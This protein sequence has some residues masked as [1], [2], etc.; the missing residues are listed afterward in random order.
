MP[1]HCQSASMRYMSAGM[2]LQLAILINGIRRLFK[3]LCPLLIRFCHYQIFL[4][5]P[6][7][8]LLMQVKHKLNSYRPQ[9]VIVQI[10]GV[11][12]QHQTNLDLPLLRFPLKI[13][14]PLVEV[15]EVILDGNMFTQP[16]TFTRFISI[17]ERK[18]IKFNYKLVM[19]LSILFHQNMEEVVDQLK[20][21]G[22]CLVDNM[23]IKFSS[24]LEI[25][26][27]P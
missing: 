10:I 22:R 15:E 19:A 25:E 14:Q 20:I 24:D 2:L 3:I 8:S 1:R 13:L 5:L 26:Q 18:L 7:T 9:I 4:T 17:V 27:I 12:N 21:H 11:S 16:L 6:Q 23:S